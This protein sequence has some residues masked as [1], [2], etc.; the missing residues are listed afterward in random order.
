MLFHG[1]ARAKYKPGT[2]A[3]G[4]YE[5]LVRREG[6]FSLGIG[7]CPETVSRDHVTAA[8][9][10]TEDPQTLLQN[11]GVPQ[12]VLVSKGHQHTGKEFVW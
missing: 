3:A 7:G 4:L 9:G 5:V 6:I 8:P 10:P 1:H 11:F 2:S 12:D